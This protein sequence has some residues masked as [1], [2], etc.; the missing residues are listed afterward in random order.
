MITLECQGTTHYL[1]TGVKQKGGK[2]NTIKS[3]YS[4]AYNYYRQFVEIVV[5]KYLHSR[6]IK[7]YGTK[8]F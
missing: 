3:L 2:A 8:T 7:H 1:K 5:K 4:R 6:I